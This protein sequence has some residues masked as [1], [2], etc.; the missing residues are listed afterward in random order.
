MKIFLKVKLNSKTIKVNK[1]DETHFEVWIKEPPIQGRAN[2]AVIKELAKY[3][4]ISLSRF[5]II[6]GRANRQK[7]IKITT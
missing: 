1:I 3:F 6:A 4:G 2:E 7:V 5:K